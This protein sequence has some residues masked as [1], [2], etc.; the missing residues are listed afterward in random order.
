MS[1]T[2]E[3]LSLVSVGKATLAD[4][5]D[6]GINRVEQLVGQDARELF[7]RLGK[8]KGTKLDPCCKDVFSAAIAQAENPN[9]PH[10]QCQ[11]HYWS[12]K[13]KSS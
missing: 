7:V 4:F 8:L 2:R 13:R 10:E 3:L 9:L 6:L 11:W 5:H 12:R 1:S